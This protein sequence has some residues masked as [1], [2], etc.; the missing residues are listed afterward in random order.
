MAM[1]RV[2]LDH[3]AP[4]RRSDEGYHGV[5]PLSGHDM[6][7]MDVLESGNEARFAIDEYLFGTQTQFR[8]SR[9]F[10]LAL[11]H[12]KLLKTPVSWW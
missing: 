11:P 4:L 9:C 3:D 2:E 12:L 6:P 1:L 8:Q 7:V 10:I 5:S